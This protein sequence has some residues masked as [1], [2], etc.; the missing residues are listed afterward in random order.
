MKLLLN[1]FWCRCRRSRWDRGSGASPALSERG[2]RAAATAPSGRGYRGGHDYRGDESRRGV[3]LIVVLGFL[4]IMLLMAVAFVMHARME[5]LVAGSTLEAMRGRQILRTGINSAMN[6]YSRY[7]WGANLVMP[8]AFQDQVFVSESSGTESMGGRTIG[9]DGIELM[10]GEV[11]DWIPS[12]YRTVAVSNLVADAQWVVVRENPGSGSSRILGRYA[13]AIFDMSG[14]I[15]ANLIARETEIAGH[16]ARA[17]SNRVR[18]SVRQVPMRLLPETA[19]AGEFKRLRRGWKGFDSLQALIHLSDGKPNDGNDS[20][21]FARWAPERREQYGPGLVSNLVSELTPFSLSAYRGGRYDRGSGRWLPEPIL[22]DGVIP[23]ATVLSPIKN[24]FPL[25]ELPDWI[26]DA[27]YDYTHDNLVPSRQDLDYPSPKNVPMFNEVLATYR[28]LEDDNGDGTSDYE[29]ELEF[30]FEHWYPFPSADNENPATFQ[31]PAPSVGGSFATSGAA[32]LWLR[33]QMAGGGGPQMVQL[34]EGVAA[35]PAAAEVDARYNNGRPYTSSNFIYR[36][37]IE[38]MAGDTNGLPSGATLRIQGMN[39]LQP[40]YMSAPGGRADMFPSGLSFPGANLVKDQERKVARGVTDP[41]LNHLTGQW[42]DE[43]EGTPNEMNSWYN[44][45]AAR[46]KF[47]AEG[48]NLYCR[49]GPME[50]PAELGFIST[51]G[52]EWETVDLFTVDAVD[53]LANL[54]ADT[55]LYATWQSAKVVYTNGTINPNTQS[56]NVLM[57]AFIDLATHEVPN[58]PTD[59]I[60]ATPL[61]ED[62]IGGMEVVYTIVQEILEETRAGTFAT[63]FQAGTDWARIPCLR[64]GGALSRMDLNNSGIGINNNQREALLRNTWGLFSPENSL[65]TVVVVAQAIKEGPGNVGIWNAADDMVT[66]E[67]RA[68]ALVWRDPFKTGQNLHHEMF[69]RM[70]RYL[71][72]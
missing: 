55:N 57:S 71:N 17:A 19:D 10:V 70:F 67:R 42:V 31:L 62:T 23:W 8:V 33:I 11:A 32:D 68:V 21:S 63:S 60:A 16:D 58:I 6:D 39:V 36:I 49:N 13:Y 40:V 65:F 46:A 2:Y 15:D 27:L 14:G 38:R 48:T 61:N 4:S 66:G 20:P 3:A 53:M 26:N 30:Q 12:A 56:S 64:Q 45:P 22:C 28:L 24:Q 5:R 51:G 25:G 37:P 18:R 1:S 29:F 54:V 50:T 47:L 69:I 72:D 34:Q 7:L 43:G 52:G 44:E 35:V 41:R 59:R 9:Q